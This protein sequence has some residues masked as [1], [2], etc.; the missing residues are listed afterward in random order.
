[1]LIWTTPS[2]CACSIEAGAGLAPTM[3]A[4]TLSAARQGRF[5]RVEAGI[6]EIEFLADPAAG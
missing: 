2:A 4:D 5:R 6:K 1:L 3:Y